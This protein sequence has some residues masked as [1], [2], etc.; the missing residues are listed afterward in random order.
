MGRT[1]Y[2]VVIKSYA[3]VNSEPGHNRP[4]ISPKPRK[5]VLVDDKSRRRAEF[6]SLKC[7][8]CHTDNVHG[9]ELL[10]AVVRTMREIEA[11]LQQV[12]TV[13]MLRARLINLLPLCAI[14]VAILPVEK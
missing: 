12:V 8:S 9:E 3:E 6:D 10:A 14:R 13:K 5:L 1:R 11:S 2:G 4:L 7:R